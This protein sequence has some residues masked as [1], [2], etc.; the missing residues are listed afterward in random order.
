LR[1]SS[2]P[3]PEAFKLGKDIPRE[4]LVSL[5]SLT[6]LK[7][8]FTTKELAEASLLSPSLVKQSLESL[9]GERLIERSA[10][11]FQVD[12]VG[13][14]L[15]AARAVGLGAD[16]E[17]VSRYLSWQE[18]EQ[19]IDY[20]LR[21]NGYATLKHHR[22]KAANRR[23][24]IDIVG[25]RSRIVVAIDCK[26]WQSSWKRSEIKRS[27][28]SQLER[29]KALSTESNLRTL[30]TSLDVELSGRLYVVPVVATL[31]ETAVK[32]HLGVPIVPAYKFA[33]FLEEMPGYLNHL[34]T[35]TTDLEEHSPK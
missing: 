11:A 14:V 23:Y 12:P 20:V 3:S 15:I 21:V 19:L 16:V 30:A 1:L 34:A 5:L 9:T 24:E 33:R 17:R 18:F 6:T 2:H 10:A 32:V 8:V 29:A 31:K 27:A 28:T 22:V 7:P 25:A 13:R 35:L 26:H 4:F